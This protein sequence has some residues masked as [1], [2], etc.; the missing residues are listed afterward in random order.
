VLGRLK[1]DVTL[2]QAQAEMNAIGKELERTYPA[3]PQLPYSISYGVNVVPL[4]LQLVDKNVRLS[5]WILFGAVVFV[6]LIAAANVANLVWVRGMVRQR[7]FAI[8]LA[9][10]AGRRRLVRQLLTESGLLALLAGMLGIAL[11]ALALSP[12]PYES[13]S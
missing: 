9:L 6:L 11:G 10:G 7:E 2:T 13:Y 5:L 8:R 12:V 3:D 4:S 1:P